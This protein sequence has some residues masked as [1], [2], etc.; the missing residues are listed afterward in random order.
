MRGSSL[1]TGS[2]EFHASVKPEGSVLCSQNLPH[3]TLF[4]S[5]WIQFTPLYLL[6]LE[7]TFILSFRLR[8]VLPGYHFFCSFQTKFRMHFS[9]TCYMSRT[10]HWL[11]HPNSNNFRYF[12][13]LCIIKRWIFFYWLQWVWCSSIATVVEI[14]ATK[15]VARS[16]LRINRYSFSLSLSLYLP[17]SVQHSG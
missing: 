8:F 4:W 12:L 15:Q 1:K 5:T 2:L 17:Y 6:S 9:H 10:C 7:L 16:W 14:Y 3:L 13:C 11:N